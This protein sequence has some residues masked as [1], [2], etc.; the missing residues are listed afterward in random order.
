MKLSD[1]K[2][3]PYNPRTITEEAAAALQTSLS[4]FGDISGIVWNRKTG[5]LVAGHQRM[6]ALRRKHGKKLVL[7]DGA[8]ES[9]DGERFPVRV[10]NWPF[11]KEKAANLAANSPF[12]GGS[13]DSGG[14]EAVL[15]DLNAADGLSGLLEGLRLNDLL[16]GAGDVFPVTG[17]PNPAED[18]GSDDSSDSGEFVTFSVPLTPSQHKTVMNAV[19]A[20]RAAGCEKVSD[21]LF[22]ICDAYLEEHGN[23]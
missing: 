16:P 1:L 11:E 7:R 6:D 4:E 2:P 21:G 8:V 19:R 13:F 10:V 22:A 18:T 9:P 20:A 14:L 23:E 5:H 17:V 15:A 3:A 12:L